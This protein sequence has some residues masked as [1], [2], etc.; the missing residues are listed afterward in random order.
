MNLTEEEAEKKIVAIIPN[1]IKAPVIEIIKREPVSR[2]EH[3]SIFAVIF[4]HSKENALKMVQSA[5]NLSLEEPKITF[6]G[7]EVD[8]KFDMENSAVFI[9]VLCR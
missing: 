5:K 4:K 1:E 9:T 7:S 3:N 8:E 2:L 6:S